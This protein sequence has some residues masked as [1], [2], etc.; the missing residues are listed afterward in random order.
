M[1]KVDTVYVVTA[2]DY[3]DYHIICVFDN[4]LDAERYIALHQLDSDSMMFI[5]E[6]DICRDKEL[7]NMI[8]YYGIEFYVHDNERQFTDYHIVFKNKT[9]E[10]N[11]TRTQRCYA[12]DIISGIIPI[13]C[14][15]V[16]ENIIK[17]LI[18]DAVTKFRA[19]EKEN[20]YL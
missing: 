1:N 19:E 2:G 11:I 8:I 7:N 3:E 5:E 17:K 14:R 15:I 6:H 18:C 20:R 4:R 10:E 9:F 16:D 13:P 12:P